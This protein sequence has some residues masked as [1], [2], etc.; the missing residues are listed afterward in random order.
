MH[1]LL[2]DDDER[3]LG[4]LAAFLAAQGHHLRTASNGREALRCIEE[5]LPDLVISD[6]QMPEM[7]GVA[8]LRAIRERFPDLPVVL[9]TGYATVNTAVAALRGRALDYLTKPIQLEELQ[10][11]IERVAGHHLPSNHREDSP[12]LQG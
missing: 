5:K 7:D 8:L 10:A 3:I 4:S 2:A 6:I 1:I 11:S 12:L 9:M